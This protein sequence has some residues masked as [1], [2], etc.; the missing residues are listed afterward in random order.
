[1]STVHSSKA[2]ILAQVRQIEIKA[3][4]LSQGTLSGSYKSAFKGRGMAFSEVREYA[5]GDDVRDIDWNVTARFGMPHIKI[6]EEERELTTMLVVDVSGSLDFGSV[7]QTKRELVAELSATLAF[8]S[9]ANRDKVG[10]IL[11]S[12][13]VELYI[14]PGKGKK[15]VLHIIRRILTHKPENKGTSPEVALHLLQQVVKKRCTAFLISDFLLPT[16]SYIN[17]LRHV[18]RKHDLVALRVCD[19]RDAEL[20]PMGWTLFADPEEGTT[21]WVNTSSKR[22]RRSYQEQSARLEAEI[23]QLLHS[24]GVDFCKVDTDKDF[25]PP[26]LRLFR[27]R[28]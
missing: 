26:L 24:S 22:L 6:F 19:R 16:Q 23:T 11:F 13:K 15:H 18:A 4:G 10:L 5:T 9:I 27:S 21:R 20:S 2:S 3:K 17:V 28:G 1:M 7:H 25:I 8:A 14:P 12:D